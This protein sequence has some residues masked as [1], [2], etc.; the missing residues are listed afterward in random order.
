M[1]TQPGFEQETFKTLLERHLSQVNQTDVLQ[2]V[3]GKAWDHFLEKGL[4]TRRDEA[5]RYIKLRQ[6]L[7]QNYTLADERELSADKIEPFIYPECRQ[8]VLVFVNGHFFPQLSRT[9]ALPAKLVVSLL[10]DGMRT[11][12]SFLNNYWAKSIKEETDPFAT[13]NTA[14]HRNGAFIYVPPKT[15]IE[16]PVQLLHVID[17]EADNQMIMPRLNLFAGA[18]SQLNLI[19]VQKVLKGKNYFVNQMTEV[20]VEEEAHVRYT[21]SLCDESAEGWHF[22]AFRANLKRNST[23]KTIAVSQGSA[24]VRNDYR[25][26]LLGENAEALLNGV[27]M[28]ADKREAHAHIFIDHQAPHCRSYQLFKSVLNDFSRSSFEGKIM[29]RQAA[30][31]TEAFQLNNNL[32]LSDY[33]HADSKPNLEIFA[34][35]VKASH[36]ATVGQLDVEQLFYMKTRGF[37]ESEA[38]NLLIYGFCEQVIEQIPLLPLQQEIS[39]WVQSYLT[40]GERKRH[41]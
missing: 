39:K 17:T 40:K 3:R 30:Q 33:A 6:L 24:T 41:G 12:G 8:S 14:L 37:P 1:M 13:L 32:L 29:V 34:D 18:H 5:Y 22:D 15:I 25:V 20:A 2:R 10:Q 7:A 16:T 23:L 21:Q 4:P 28:L 27:W 38:K 31:K 35:D 36:G 19:T 26:N 9:E 11:Y